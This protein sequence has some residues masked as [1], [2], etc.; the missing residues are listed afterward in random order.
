[1]PKEYKTI[2]EVVGPL[3][4]VDQV[5]GIKYDELVR[6]RQASGEERIGKVLEVDHDRALV[7]LFNSSQG[8]RISDAKA[9]FLGRGIEIKLA[10]EIVGRVFDGMGRPI[11]GAGDII[12]QKMADINGTPLNPVARNYPSEFIETGISAI[13]GLN[14]LVRG[15]K[16]PIFSGSG[17][18]HAKLAAQ[19]ARQAKVKDRSESFAVV[20]AAIGI[21]FEEA[22]YFIQD[23]QRSGAI[24]R[25]VLFM[26]LA[27]DPAIERIATPR[28]A[29]TCAEYLAYELGMHVLIILTDITNYAEAIREVSAARKEVP[30]RRGYPGYM[31]TDLASLYERAGRIKEKKGSITQI[32]ILTMPEDDKTHP[33]PDLTGYITE[34]QIILSR[35]LNLKGI[36]P[37][38]DVLPSLSRL[39]DKGI[40]EGKT[41]EDHSETMN[42]LFSA[43]ARGKEAKELSTILGEA[44]LSDV[45]KLYAQFA[46]EFEERYVQQGPRENR[47][48][49]KTLTIGWKCLTILPKTELKR[50]SLDKIAKYLPEGD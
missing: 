34:G 20:F 32:P 19:I 14:T 38:I 35:E 44:A 26:N 27:A 8:L 30:G 13:D 22:N 1:M 18:P 48:I 42:Q 49:E 23:F 41:R 33:I 9:M 3:M 5:E 37:P 7:Q 50:I 4:L 29:I 25:S 31:Y 24:E 10:P 12:P 16:L 36:Y 21:T 39:K 15:Q 6:I 17:L 2:R 40:G 43:Y 46:I 45:D 47:P 28:M 11:D